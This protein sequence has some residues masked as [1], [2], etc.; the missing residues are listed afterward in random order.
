MNGRIYDPAFHRFLQPDNYVQDPSN[1]QNY[2][3]YAYC[4]NNP[5]KYTDPSGEIIWMA[6]AVGAMLGAATGAASYIGQAVKTG[7]WKWSQ[8]GMSV[9]GGAVVG[10]LTWGTLPGCLTFEYAVGVIGTGFAAGFMPSIGNMQVGDWN[11]SLS[12]AIALGNV[13][14]IG[15][16]LSVTYSDGNFSFSAGVGIMSNSNYHNFGKNGLE[17]RESILASWNDGKTGVSLG[18]NFWQGGFNQRTGVLGLSSGK[19]SMTYENDGSPFGGTLGDGQ[20]RRRTAAM[21]LTAGEFSAGFNIFT[22][23][24]ILGGE[25]NVKADRGFFGRVFNKIPIGTDG[26]YGANLPYCAAI[27]RG[28]KH[29]AGIAYLSF[30]NYRAG[31]NSYRYIGHPIQNIGAHYYAS[32]Q[33]G[34]PSLS[35][36]IYPYFQYKTANIFT[37]W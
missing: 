4:Y 28:I 32:P 37:S 1:T 22:G 15:A 2:N 26:G 17:I 20:D 24:R 11:I 27:E 25:A 29:R 18:T 6:V 13:T 10:A 36:N 23:D 31:L 3:R 21:T 35:N 34:F 12:P 19:F 9:L 7:N 8:F 14:G 16:N 5:L 33:V 30:R